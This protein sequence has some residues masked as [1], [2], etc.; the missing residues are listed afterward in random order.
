LTEAYLG[1]IERLDPLLHAVIE[2]NPDARDIAA[3]RDRERR[4][5]RAVT[6]HDPDPGHGQHR[7]ARRDGDDGRS[8][9]LVGSRVAVTPRSSRGC[10][11]REP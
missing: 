11:R 9:A 10:A 3:R 8:L 4:A 5:G 1:R 7:D 6:L 2:T